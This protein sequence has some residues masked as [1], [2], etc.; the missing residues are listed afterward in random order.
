MMVGMRRSVQNFLACQADSDD[1][2]LVDF[3][4]ERYA[5]STSKKR[6]FHRSV[7]FMKVLCGATIP[8]VDFSNQPFIG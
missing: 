8:M 3:L 7:A 4:F 1:L 6:P 5:L 2:A